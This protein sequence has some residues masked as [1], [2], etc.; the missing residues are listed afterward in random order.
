MLDY[1]KKARASRPIIS[2]HEFVGPFL[3]DVQAAEKRFVACGLH[4]CHIANNAA[5]ACH[6]TSASF[7]SLEWRQLFDALICAAQSGKS[8]IGWQHLVE[9]NARH[10]SVWGINE[11]ELWALLHTEWNKELLPTLA[12]RV[13]EFSRRLETV[14]SHVASIT[15]L[16]RKPN[17]PD[18]ADAARAEVSSEFRIVVP[19]HLARRRK[20]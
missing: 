5:A 9:L 2:I 1:A 20:G 10:H 16:L 18:V 4:Y 19:T 12:L 14:K 13:A 7:T 6:L 8:E 17:I 11:A 3:E 15:A